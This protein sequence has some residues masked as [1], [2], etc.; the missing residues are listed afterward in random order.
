[1]PGKSRN[2]RLWKRPV[3]RL[4]LPPGL[5]LIFYIKAVE[6]SMIKVRTEAHDLLFL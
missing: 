4:S 5:A 2:L 1:M 3:I 6:E